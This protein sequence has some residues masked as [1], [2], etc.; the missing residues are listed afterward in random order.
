MSTL[1]RETRAETFVSAT[2]IDLV[3]DAMITEFEPDWDARPLI[4][5]DPDGDGACIMTG[6]EIGYMTVTLQLWDADPPPQASEAWEASGETSVFWAS[7]FIDF[8]SDLE[9]ED[10][11]C[12]LDVPH[13]APLRLRVHARHL[14]RQDPLPA[15]AEPEEYLIQVWPEGT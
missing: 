15:G 11:A 5:A 4:S 1:I 6:H 3:G 14:G 8:S 10:P 7:A 9:D 12:R 13:P 2:T